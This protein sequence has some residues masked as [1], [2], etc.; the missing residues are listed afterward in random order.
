MER[1]NKL[2]HILTTALILKIVD[3][4]KDFVVCIDTWKEGLGGFLLQ[5]LMLWH[6]NL[7]N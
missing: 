6:M 7:G 5:E 4:F 2:K 1:F 3:P